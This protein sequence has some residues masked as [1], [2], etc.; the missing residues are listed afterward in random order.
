[1]TDKAREIPT[2]VFAFSDIT[3]S[4]DDHISLKN[5]KGLLE[6]N[7]N[8]TVRRPKR[9][10]HA[11]RTMAALWDNIGKPI[12]A[13]GI[14]SSVEDAV[15]MYAFDNGKSKSI[16][17]WKNERIPMSFC[18]TVPCSINA[19]GFAFKDPVAVDIRTGKVYKVITTNG[20]LANVPVY[21]SPVM[22]T[23]KKNLELQ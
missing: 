14:T 21:D 8:K 3:Y 11:V 4:K 13:S 12:D 1:M 19:P 20:V 17:F 15:S 22:I 6:T 10:F 16:V 9:S 18:K 2:A 5:Y 7:E 23:E